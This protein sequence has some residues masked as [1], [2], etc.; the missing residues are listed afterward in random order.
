MII[1]HHNDHNTQILTICMILYNFL[2]S[3]WITKILKT[4]FQISR[5]LRIT[6]GFNIFKA[7]GSLGRTWRTYRRILPPSS[8]QLLAELLLDLRIYLRTDSIDDSRYD[9]RNIS[10]LLQIYIFYFSLQ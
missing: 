10:I 6:E 9:I 2:K 7:A 3:I 8:R 5:I 4:Y 1:I